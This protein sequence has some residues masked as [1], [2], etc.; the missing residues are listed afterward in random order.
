MTVRELIA[1]L[2]KYDMDRS[3][4][5]MS[6]R[7]CDDGGCCDVMEDWYSVVVRPGEPKNRSTQN[8]RP[9]DNRVYILTEGG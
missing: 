2:L 5:A 3:V 6:T 9:A 7:V 1:E 4:V 8:Y